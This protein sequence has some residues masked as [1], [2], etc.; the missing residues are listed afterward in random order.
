MF[1]NMTSNI[2][3]LLYSS[4]QDPSDVFNPSDLLYAHIARNSPEQGEAGA[5]L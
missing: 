1:G 2:L 3:K 4:G 5:D